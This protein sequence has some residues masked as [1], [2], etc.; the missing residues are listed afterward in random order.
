MA[1][2]GDRGLTHH[3]VNQIPKQDSDINIT[4]WQARKNKQA[5]AIMPGMR[6]AH[7]L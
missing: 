6:A 1:L 3:K 2:A 5:V 4:G 7:H